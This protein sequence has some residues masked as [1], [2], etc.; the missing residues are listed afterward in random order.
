MIYVLLDHPKLD[1]AD[2]SSLESIMYGASPMSPARLVEGIERIGPVF[3]QLYG[4]TECGG[5]ATSLWREHHD[6]KN[7][8]R[9]ASCG[10]PMPNA[11]VAVSR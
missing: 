1:A 6:P 9:L 3:A 2:L 4:Q 10:L 5:I 11:R 7:L 8:A